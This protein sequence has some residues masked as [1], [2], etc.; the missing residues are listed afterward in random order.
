MQR[1][2]HGFQRKGD[3]AQHCEAPAAEQS[4]SAKVRQALASIDRQA[5]GLTYM[6]I[7]CWNAWNTI[8]FSGR[9]LAARDRQQ[10]GHGHA[11]DDAPSGMHRHA[12]RMRALASRRAPLVF[13]KTAPRS[14]ARWWHRS[15]RSSSAARPGDFALR[16]PVDRV[17]PGM[18]AFG[19]GHDARILPRGGAGTLPPHRALYRL[20][21]AVMFS[22]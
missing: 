6:G 18:R 12:A 9:I 4:I 1:G 13:A 14:P 16:R 2:M 8:A 11:Y 21:E 10:L 19:R 3:A 15:A 22:R 20:A 5:P 7:G 17:S